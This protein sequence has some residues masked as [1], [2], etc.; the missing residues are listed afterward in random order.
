MGKIIDA[1]GFSCPQPVM[2]TVDAIKA[3]DNGEIIVLVDNEAARENVIRAAASLGWLATDIQSENDEYRI[4][5]AK[6]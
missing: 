2:M 5:M 1:R 4:T 6:E 3:T